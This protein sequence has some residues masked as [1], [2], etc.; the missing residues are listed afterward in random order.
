MEKR[1]INVT[2]TSYPPFYLDN[3]NFFSRSMMT[4]VVRART[5]AH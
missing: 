4:I 3:F 5:R 2:L 1:S